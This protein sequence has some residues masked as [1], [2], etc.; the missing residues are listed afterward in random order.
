[1]ENKEY[2]LLDL[3]K[4]CWTAFVSYVWHPFVFLIRFGLKNWMFLMG[5]AVFGV[6]ISV[7]V[8]FCLSKKYSGSMLVQ[9]QVGQSSNYVNLL[10]VL[11]DEDEELKANKLGLSKEELKPLLKVLPHYVYPMDSLGVGY[12]INFKDEDDYSEYPV[13][14][15][16]FCIE[17]MAKDSLFLR[18]VS[19]NII[20]YLE[21]DDY[22]KTANNI[23]L[24][25]MQNNISVL[26]NELVMLDS[27]RNIE[28][29][30]KSRQNIAYANPSTGMMVQQQTRLMHE[31]I[32]GLS[33]RL[34]AYENA[35]AYN[36]NAL[37]VMTPMSIRAVPLNHWSKTFI[38]YALACMVLTYAGLLAWNYRKKI[39]DFV[40]A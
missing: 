18:N 13:L 37:K 35:L 38:K 15:S 27:L 39:S 5:A 17:V 33:S 28:Y 31:D 3:V 20:N 21:N 1:M 8:P 6:I 14:S 40:N 4:W 16:V 34:N 23:R 12:D 7:V 25:N 19:A 22:V 2:D 36:S 24:H 9:A 10:S 26:R 29:L 11:N 30:E 32:I